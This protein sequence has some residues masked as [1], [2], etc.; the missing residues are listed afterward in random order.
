[1]PYFSCR[2]RVFGATSCME[3]ELLIC[4]TNSGIISIRTTTVSDTIA[5]AHVQPDSLSNTWL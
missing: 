1:L 3:R 5:S 4:L 2:A